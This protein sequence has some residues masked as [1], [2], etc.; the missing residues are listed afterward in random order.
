MWICENR[1]CADKGALVTSKLNSLMHHSRTFDGIQGLK[2]SSGNNILCSLYCISKPG[3]C[4][5]EFSADRMANES[6]APSGTWWWDSRK[7]ACCPAGYLRLQTREW[8]WLWGNCYAFGAHLVGNLDLPYTTTFDD[9]LEVSC[10]GHQKDAKRHKTEK[11]KKD[12]KERPEQRVWIKGI[13]RIKVWGGCERDNG[14]TT[15]TKK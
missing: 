1:S 14:Q 8:W 12:R 11:E 15:S 5:W 10:R 4:N 6:A 7:I 9:F 2:D 3:N 13:R